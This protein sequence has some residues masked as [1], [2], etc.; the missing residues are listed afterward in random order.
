MKASTPLLTRLPI[1]LLGS[2]S[3]LLSACYDD[4]TDTGPVTAEKAEAFVADAEAQLLDSWIARERASWVQENFITE[5]TDM[6]VAEASRKNTELTVKLAQEATRFDDLEL[7]D[8]LERKLAKL[9]LSLVLPAPAD[10][11]KTR[12]LA[13]IEAAMKSRFARGKYCPNGAEGDC[14]DIDAIIATFAESRDAEEL[15]DVWQ[16][17]RTISPPMRA[18]FERYAELGNE[19]ASELGFADLGSMWRSKYDMDP[20]AFAAE[21]DRLWEQVKPLYEALHCH[22]RARM[23]DYYGTDVVETSGPMPAHV[24]G[25]IWAQTWANVYDLVAPASVD[26]GSDSGS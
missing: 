5:D 16:G 9:K 12:E 21:L 24:L 18:E 11:G 2:I 10:A 13:E 6:L 4:G 22:V 19:G 7:S 23:A 25:N 8:D 26:P 15:L 3:I 14:L 1:L 17:W 20:D